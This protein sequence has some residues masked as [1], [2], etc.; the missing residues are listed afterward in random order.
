MSKKYISEVIKDDYKNWK[1]GDI[2][3]IKSP[4]GSGKS[5]FI[6]K[7][8]LNWC[9]DQHKS[10]LLLSNR[11]LLY[12]QQI[13]DIES[14][15]TGTFTKITLGLYQTFKESIENYDYVVCDECHYFFEDASF[16]RFTDIIYK[17]IQNYSDGV[18]ILLSA[19]PELLRTR[20]KAKISEEY[21][22]PLIIKNYTLY[23]YWKQKTVPMIIKQIRKEYPSEKIMYFSRSAK[24]AYNMSI[25]FDD[26]T[27]ICSEGNNQ[28]RRYIDKTER[29]NIEQESHFNCNLLCAT[30]ALDNGINVKDVSVK[31]IILDVF[32]PV[33]TVQ[34]L[35]RK[36]LEDENEHIN[37][38]IKNCGKKLIQGFMDE[39]ESK[40]EPSID[41]EKLTEED[42]AEK[43]HKKGTGKML[44]L[45]TGKNGGYEFEVNECMRDWYTY[46]YNFCKMCLQSKDEYFNYICRK[47]EI[48]ASQA[49]D[50]VENI[51]YEK[52]ELVLQKWKGIKIYTESKE[53]QQ[54]IDEVFL[55][56]E[57]RNLDGR[58]K[59]YNSINQVIHGLGL[60]YK[61]ES[62]TDWSRKSKHRGKAYWTVEVIDN[63]GI[64]KENT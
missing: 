20:L 62:K 50:I 34:C 53:K 54:F 23:E 48:D 37:I 45:I 35:G 17:K 3:L 9:K 59:G 30:T 29:N 57:G 19:T 63:I 51:E 32:T 12:K 44:D 4:T 22:L 42:F 18:I 28:Y 31:H 55:V 38:Y 61:I 33:S 49:I 58:L 1:K 41:L 47:L 21:T 25:L 11:T 13:S 5:E 64:G 39:A 56:I 36:R 6:K 26:S 24:D 15:L 46:L 7:K 8:L 40:L 52:L 2:I 43:Y 27:F 60:S 14:S 10:M 16:N